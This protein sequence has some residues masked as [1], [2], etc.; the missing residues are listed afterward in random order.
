MGAYKWYNLSLVILLFVLFTSCSDDPVRSNM[1]SEP[2][3]SVGEIAGERFHL[4]NSGELIQELTAPDAT[5]G[6][7]FGA[8]IA[9]DNKIAV[10]GAPSQQNDTGVRTGAAYI[11]SKDNNRWVYMATLW[12]DGE[13]FGTFGGQVAVS[14]NVIAVMDINTLY[15]FER[16]GTGWNLVSKLEPE[17]DDPRDQFGASLTIDKKYIAVGDPDFRDY[18]SVHLYERTATGW[19]FA[20]Q[21]YASDRTVADGFGRD[22]SLSGNTLLSSS[23]LV[24]AGYV[25]DR[26]GNNWNESAIL[27]PD[28]PLFAGFGTSVSLSGKTAVIGRPIADGGAAYIFEKSRN[29]WIQIKKLTDPAGHDEDRLGQSVAID[30]RLIAVGAPDLSTAPGKVYYAVK[31]GKQWSDLVLLEP[32]GLQ[33]GDQLGSSVAVSMSTVMAG[34]PGDD[35]EASDAGKVY[36]FE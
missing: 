18:G 2:T 20:K 4:Q 31:Q 17:G 29:S 23:S 34:A 6:A 19:Q 21:I 16:K 26:R 25:F 15:V 12:P 10:I 11:F 3:G 27:E 14:G 36:V 28:D 9:V 32:D 13:D 1:D 24:N 8:S 33:A 22:V 35:D 5:E 30:N 7:R